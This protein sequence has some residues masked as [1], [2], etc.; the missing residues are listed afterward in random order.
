M[1]LTRLPWARQLEGESMQRTS[2]NLLPAKSLTV[3]RSGA[4]DAANGLEVDCPM[5]M[6]A[7]LLQR[8]ALCEHGQG[9]LLDPN[10]NSLSLRCL[11]VEPVR[12]QPL[13]SAAHD[14]SFETGGC[15]VALAAGDRA[16][17][18]A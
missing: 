2:T 1:D 16:G 6:T 7:V 9:L 13:C 8:C 10:T 5:L 12:A 3:R 17:S 15:R 14:S 18:G 4:D 11:F